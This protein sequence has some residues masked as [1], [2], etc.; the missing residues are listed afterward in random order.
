MNLLVGIYW[1]FV[2]LALALPEGELLLRDGD[3]HFVGEPL[4]RE[5]A[6]VVDEDLTLRS[7]DLCAKY[8][9]KHTMCLSVPGKTCGSEYQQVPLT[10]AERKQMVD[11]HN[12]MRNKV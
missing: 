6:H 2:P 5:D 7:D 1:L 8:G 11:L 4:L 12:D 10:D 3:H 9:S